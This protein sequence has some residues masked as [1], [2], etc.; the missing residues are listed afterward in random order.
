MK[1]ETIVTHCAIENKSGLYSVLI[2]NGK[3]VRFVAQE[4][5]NLNDFSGINT[6]DANGMLMLPPLIET[7]IHLD[8]ACISSRCHLCEG[9]LS[10]AIT[11]TSAA[12]SEFT[13]SD[14]YQRG[15][16][17]IERS[18]KQGTGYMR[19]HVEI[20]PVIGLVGFN[21]IKQLKH[22][23]AW[24]ISIEICVFP[25]EGLYNN[26]GTYELLEQ[27]LKQ[28]ADLLGGC[29]YT[30]SH[31][32][33]QLESLFELAS[34][35]DVD[36]DFHLDFDLKPERSLLPYLIELTKKYYYAGRVTVGHVT[37]L[38][39]L[40]HGELIAVA[41]NMVEAGV[42]LTALPSTDLFL[43]GRE[44]ESAIPRGVA[45]LMPL[46]DAGVRCSLSSNNIENPFTPY[47]DGSLIRQSNL[48]ANIAQLGTEKQMNQ[49][50]KWVSSDAAKVMRLEQY[51]LCEGMPANAIFF[52]A[53]NKAKVIATIKAPSMGIK[54]GKLTF[55]RPETEIYPD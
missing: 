41:K 42:N 8:K 50:F 35:Y 51:G 43:M 46:T 25:Q 26:E 54:N 27:A 30:D 16:T 2:S 4:D 40:P 33:K 28:G 9:T 7:H 29:P 39:M 11:Q 22:D 1:V 38:S 18:I 36:L 12:K 10:E 47:G 23:Y 53:E 14:I 17:V 45:P 49:C 5:I 37:Q 48:Y 21:A 32:K 13:Y 34:Q 24:G 31:P 20:D 3:F 52:A 44:F 55:V 15:K 19:A 6:I